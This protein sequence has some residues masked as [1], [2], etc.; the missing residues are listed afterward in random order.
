MKKLIF[1]CIFLLCIFE[2][3]AQTWTVLT[4]NS[5]SN[6]KGIHFPSSTVGY[7]VGDNGTILKTT[8]SGTTWTSVTSAFAGDW[9]WD[10]HFIGVDTGYV[11][12]ETDPG[13][14]P[15]GL[16][17]VLK[18]VNGG[19]TWT[20]LLS[21]LASPVRD[22]F[23]LS[24]DTV[25]IC[26]GAE[27]TNSRI[28]KSFDGGATW[29]QIGLTYYDAM[30]GGLYFLHA[31]K[32]FLGIYESVFGTYNPG[33]A[34]WLSTLNGGTNFTSN[35]IPSSI[36]YWNFAS[37]FP[38]TTVGYFTRSTYVGTN[39]VYVRKT[40]DGGSTWTES[41][42]P[43]F[44]GSIYGLD[45][46]N[47]S[48]GYIVGAAGVIKKT[49]DNGATW[50]SQTSNTT[51]E[52][53]SVCFVTPGLGFTAGANG[54]ILKYILGTDVA[55]STQISESIQ[56][57]PNPTSEQVT[58]TVNPNLIGSIY[59]LTDVLGRTLQTAKMNAQRTIIHMDDYPKGLYLL[60]IDGQNQQ[61]IK[62]V[63]N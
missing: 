9:F 41:A 57:Y 58:I 29:T 59:H 39:A 16:G 33:L 47:P 42:I 36:S 35:V 55:E 11:C 34:T 12:G 50:T 1:L 15:C 54:T 30:L 10:V 31:N 23:V 6:L 61:A 51:Q 44:A 49:S 38:S 46:V 52:L 48:T 5:T 40:T 18:T 60:Q 63:K 17:I 26:G 4:T 27:G 43:S 25:F 3:Q 62:I 28:A 45:F 7:A 2:L 56:V 22:L 8:T 19:T 53:R 24:K 21:G 14:N 13:S 37:D 20:T 32:G